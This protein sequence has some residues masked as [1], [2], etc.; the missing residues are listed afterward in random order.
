M[1]LLGAQECPFFFALDFKGSRGLV[2]SVSEIDPKYLKFNVEGRQNTYTETPPQKITLT[3]SAIDISQYAE[4]F[5]TVQRHIKHGNSYLLNLTLRTPI[6]TNCSLSE[7]FQISTA[8]YKVLCE[9]SWLTF[10]PE[11]FVTIEDGKISS[12]PMKGTIRANIPGAIQIILNDPKEMAEHATIV[13]LIRNDLSQ[14]ASRVEVNRF[15]Y[16]EKVR[17]N[18]HDLLQVSSEISGQLEV[19]YQSQIGDIIFAL[20]PAGSITGAPKQKTVEII[21]AVEG[22]PR[23][24]YTGV[25]G[26]FDGS[27]L[28]SGVMIRFIEKEDNQLFFRSGGGITM[29]S[30]LEQEYQEY[31]DKIYLPIY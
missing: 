17:T 10:S 21:E 28:D 9:D 15:R 12:Y 26:F 2:Q 7:I 30:N 24:F 11:P 5:D 27:R 4:K 22:L 19:G 14:V 6:F 16:L 20:L 13:D 8:K 29:Q 18:H 1:N 25:C 31:A 23:G 3:K